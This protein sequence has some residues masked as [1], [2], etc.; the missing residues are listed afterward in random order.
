MKYITCIICPNSC[1][2]EVKEG[3]NGIGVCG[4][5]CKR[6]EEFAIKEINNPTRSICT[7]VKTTYSEMPM[8]PVRTDG[9]IPLSYIFPLMNIINQKV[10]DHPVHSGEVIIE[11]V[12]ETGVNVISS[13]DMYYFIEEVK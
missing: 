13:S 8:L 9:E 7:T 1:E 11:N 4:N 10:I 6:G 2:M 12:L 5:I 3:K